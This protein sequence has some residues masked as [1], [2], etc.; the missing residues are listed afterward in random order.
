VAR[1][2]APLSVSLDGWS[3]GRVVDVD[4]LRWGSSGD[5]D[6]AAA[7]SVHSQFEAPDGAPYL[8]TVKP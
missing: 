5:A 4:W 3:I 6:V 8:S 1:A 2:A 7:R